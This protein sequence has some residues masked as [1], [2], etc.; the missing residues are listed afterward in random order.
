MFNSFSSGE[1]GG[2]PKPRGPPPSHRVN[3]TLQARGETSP[4]GSG[5]RSVEPDEDDSEVEQAR[6]V[7]EAKKARQREKGKE[8][9]RRKRERDKRAREVGHPYAES[10]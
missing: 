10:R 5:R 6:G 9:Q 3:G 7:E 8:R 2:S 4:L 1:V